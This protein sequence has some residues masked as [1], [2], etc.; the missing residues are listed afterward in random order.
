MSEFKPLTDA[1]VEEIFA[2]ST[3]IETVGQ[4]WRSYVHLLD[5]FR[6]TDEL[7]KVVDAILRMAEICMDN[8]PPCDYDFRAVFVTMLTWLAADVKV[9]QKTNGKQCLKGE[10]LLPLHIRESGYDHLLE[11]GQ[12]TDQISKFL[13][14]SI[15]ELSKGAGS[16]LYDLIIASASAKSDEESKE[17][18]EKIGSVLS[19]IEDERKPA[20]IEEIKTTVE[21]LQSNAS[22]KTYCITEMETEFYKFACGLFE[23]KPQVIEDLNLIRQA[24][25]DG[26]SSMKVPYQEFL[27]S[28]GLEACARKMSDF[29]MGLVDCGLPDRISETLDVCRQSLKRPSSGKSSSPKKQKRQSL[30]DV[31]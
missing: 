9:S 29:R 3:L 31:D 13:K 8:P 12:V 25:L 2:D 5:T 16:G 18:N 21:N 19:A 4:N 23:E 1:E 30:D 28:F 15:K 17:I 24:Y 22:F 7:S 10:V 27:I 26:D 11:C 14:E 20:L 6:A